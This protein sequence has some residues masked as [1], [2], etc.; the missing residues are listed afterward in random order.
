[1]ISYDVGRNI[2]RALGVGGVNGGAAGG[3]A[4]AA[5]RG[6]VVSTPS[7]LTSHPANVISFPL[8]NYMA[9]LGKLLRVLVGHRS[10]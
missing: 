3:D 1:M 5:E 6:G 7:T 10:E 4:A 2:R 8:S 9:R